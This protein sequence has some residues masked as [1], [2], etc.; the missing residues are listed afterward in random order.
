MTTEC[1]KLPLRDHCKIDHRTIFTDKTICLKK[2]SFCNI[3]IFKSIK[4][5]A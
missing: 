5:F 4:G 2:K 1:H 3:N